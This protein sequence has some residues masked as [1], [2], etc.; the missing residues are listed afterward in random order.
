MMAHDSANRV[1]GPNGAN[2]LVA[3]DWMRFDQ[4]VLAPRKPG[5]LQQHAIWNGDFADVVKKGA[6]MQRDEIRRFEMAACPERRRVAR[7]ALAVTV[8]SGISGF[9]DAGEREKQRFCGFE[10]VDS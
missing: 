8:R 10:L 4:R 9:D 7:Q 1:E 6:A 3:N 5:R 2:E